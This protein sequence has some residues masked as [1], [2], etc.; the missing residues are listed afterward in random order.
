MGGA[1]LVNGRDFRLSDLLTAGGSAMGTANQRLTS[2]GVPS[3]LRTFEMG[4]TFPGGVQ[5]CP[6]EGELLVR[7][8]RR[9][10]SM[11]GQGAG[12][13]S[14]ITITAGYIAAPALVPS[15]PSVPASPSGVI[16]P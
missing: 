2:G 12:G 3:L 7:R 8:P 14:S 1:G 13:G 11:G 4:L 16:D 15:P 6:G 9:A 10:M 5:V